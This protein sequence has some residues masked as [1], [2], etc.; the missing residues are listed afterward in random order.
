MP[1]PVDTVLFD[2][3]DTLCSY[4]RTVPE[5]L[6]L[7]F[8]T[9]GVDPFFEATDYY[10]RYD[11]FVTDASGMHELRE[12]CFASLAADAGRDPDLGRE[13]ATVYDAERDQ[14]NVE[15][16]PG[17]AEAVSSLATDHRLAVVTN[18]SPEMQS[19]KLGALPFADAFEHVVHAGYDTP[20]KP[21]PDAFHR[22]L[23]LL[24]SEADSTVHVG[25]SL[26]SDVAGA[27]AA[28]VRAAWLAVDGGSPGA[29]SPTPEYVLGSLAE[30]TDPP[31]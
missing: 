20:A 30:L 23:D 10:A 7:A 27:Q 15:P 25:N 16:L 17:A 9:V 2:L 6:D 29:D 4:R 1:A 14:S 11:E 5:M 21:A 19:Q 12:Q 31:W 26:R 28:G 22:V 8:E 13:L 18:G 24:G 3:D